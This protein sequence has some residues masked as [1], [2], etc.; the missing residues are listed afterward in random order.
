[1]ARQQGYWV[2]VL[3]SM[4]FAAASGEPAPGPSMPNTIWNCNKWFLVNSGDTCATA[5]AAGNIPASQFFVWNPDVSSD[6]LTNFWPTYYYCIGVDRTATSTTTTTTTTK[7]A[8]TTTT[9]PKPSTQTTT[10]SRGSSTTTSRITSSA[11]A[12]YSIRHPIVTWNI[13]TKTIGH[14]RP[15]KETQRG[16]PASCLDWHLVSVGQSCQQIVNRYFTSLSID[17]LLDWNPE[18]LDDCSGLQIGYYVC[19]RV[20]PSG[21]LTL[22]FNPGSASIPDS[23]AWTPTTLPSVDT[24]FTPVPTQ[25]PLPPTCQAYY[26]A[27]DGD[28]CENVLA[29]NPQITREQFFSWNTFL[30]GN[31]DGMWAG[32]FYCIW[33]G[34]PGVL[35]DPPTVKTK[36]TSGVPANTTADCIGW[37]Q[38]TGGDDCDLMV[39]MF[40]RFSRA[41][42]VKW[43]PT[44]KTDCSG[45]KDDSW[46]CVA[47]P[48]TPTTRT[49]GMPSSSPTGRPSTTTTGK[50]TTTTAK[51]TTTT[52]KTTTAGSGPVTTPTPII[53]GMVAGCRRFYF[54]RDGD[55]CWAIANAAGIN[56]E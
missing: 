11:N 35:P 5:Q 54:T 50:T 56:L 2:A 27:G 6:C 23:T 55:G 17:D 46:Y 38:A 9:G 18:L 30:N 41:D 40:G 39:A 51:T 26:Q 24:S 34:P 22:T 8:T 1:M 3:L 52:A 49:E 4:L 43:N 31:C 45:V 37:Y 44:V 36:P 10:S 15:P 25:G 19:I 20:K 14:D 47:V 21:S 53:P 32:Y 48:G 13:T 12:T 16:Q 42:F 7:G 29:Q 33:A 28:R